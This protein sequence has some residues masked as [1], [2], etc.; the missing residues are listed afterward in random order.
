M[1]ASADLRTWVVQQLTGITGGIHSRVSPTQ[2][3]PYTVITGITGV[4]W[5][6]ETEEGDENTVTL[7]THD[8]TTAGSPKRVEQI[9]AEIDDILH[10]ASIELADGVHGWMERDGG[11]SA[12]LVEGTT[13]TW[14]GVLRYRAHISE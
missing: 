14:R 11:E 4:P 10:G 6:T 13:V 8:D 12:T 2:P 5:D 9:Q 1:I 3:K 7:A